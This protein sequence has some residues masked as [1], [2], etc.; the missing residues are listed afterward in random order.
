MANEPTETPIIKAISGSGG[1]W[2]TIA[3]RLGTT[4]HAIKCMVNS[5]PELQILYDAER[6]RILGIAESCL[7]DNRDDP[8]VAKWMKINVKN[9]DA[10]KDRVSH[11]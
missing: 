11:A 5:D 2:T 10:W 9:L 8:S 4:V 1:I 3:R 6:C 7:Y